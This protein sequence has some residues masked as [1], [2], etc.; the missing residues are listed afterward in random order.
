MFGKITKLRAIIDK[1]QDELLGQ[2]ASGKEDT[3]PPVSMSDGNL[4]HD[5]CFN[6]TTSVPHGT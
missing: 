3:P 6:N 5:V 4:K 2:V 1:H